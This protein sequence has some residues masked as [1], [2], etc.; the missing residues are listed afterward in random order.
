[1]FVNLYLASSGL[2][3]ASIKKAF[4]LGSMDGGVWGWHVAAIVKSQDSKTK[5]TKWVVIDSE[6]GRVI[7]NSYGKE[8]LETERLH[9]N[10]ATE[11]SKETQEKTKDDPRS[12]SETIWSSRQWPRK[13]SRDDQVYPL[14]VCAREEVSS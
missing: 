14:G 9:K 8:Y 13:S 1:M 2:N 4:V 7:E 6:I 10:Y 5:Q 11:R 12:S 3:R